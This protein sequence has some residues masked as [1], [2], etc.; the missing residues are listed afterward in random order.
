M[1]G[2]TDSVA[3]KNLA[4]RLPHY[5]AL[6]GGNAALALGPWLVRL[7]DTGPVSAGFWRM[8]LPLPLF[9]L[10]ALRERAANAATRR[11]VLLLLAAGAFFAADLASWHIGIE[12]T[13]L[14]NSTLFGNSGSIVLMVWG[15]I[16]LRRAP[17]RREVLA[18]AA[19]FGG[20]AILMGR[21]LEI[22]TATLVGDLFCLLAGIFYVF[23]LLP[24]Q[25]A[26]VSMGQWSVLTLVCASAAPMLLAI[27][28]AL[29][30]PVLPG[31]AAGWVPVVGL[32]VSS[33]VIG[34]GLLVY[35]L[36]H[37]PPLIIGMALLTQPAIAA[38]V[39]WMAFG[40]TLGLPDIAGMALV[41]VALVLAKSKG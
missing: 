40:E 5:A 11:T 16:A 10:L 2:A 39:G 12:R 1:T 26:R 20:A 32:A 7:A 14:G 36:K 24:A 6:M 23:Y 41:S 33:Q 21:S 30:E 29:G 38:A 31:T 3:E 8:L 35:S 22:S 4:P 25:S 34:Q 37:F 15:L 18:L 9:V 28:L 27:A 13:R 17:S 19:A